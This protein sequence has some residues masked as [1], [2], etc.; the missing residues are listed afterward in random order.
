MTEKKQP[1]KKPKP[2]RSWTRRIFRALV[3][4]V[5]LLIL[6]AGAGVAV[7]ELGWF[8]S[9]MRNAVIKQIEQVTG[10]TVELKRFHF[11]PLALRV[12]LTGLTVHGREPEGTPPLL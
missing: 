8:D 1:V 3:A 2:K 11:A 4:L 9:S 6:L 12:E 5:V 10:G 7:L